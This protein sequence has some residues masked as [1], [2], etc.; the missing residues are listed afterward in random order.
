MITEMVVGIVCGAIIKIIMQDSLRSIG[1]APPPR[2][3]DKLEDIY[4]DE[5]HLFR[6]EEHL[7]KRLFS[8]I[9]QKSDERIR[10]KKQLEKELNRRENQEIDLFWRVMH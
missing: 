10:E 4:S 5:A 9:I 2:I 1:K 7:R 8:Q 3:S 6:E